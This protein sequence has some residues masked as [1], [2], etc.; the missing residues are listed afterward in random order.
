MKSSA[1]MLRSFCCAFVKGEGDLV[2]R[3][4]K[5]GYTVTHVQSPIGE[6]A[7]ARLVASLPLCLTHGSQGSLRWAGLG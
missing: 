2:R 7:T 1:S 5:M 6:Q 4:V 3:L